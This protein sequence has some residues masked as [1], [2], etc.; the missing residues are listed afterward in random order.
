MVLFGPNGSGK[1]NLLEALTLLFGTRQS[2]ALFN[3]SSMPPIGSQPWGLSA[4]ITNDVAAT[5]TTGRLS[6]DLADIDS[7]RAQFGS[8]FLD[9]RNW[10]QNTD[11]TWL[12]SVAAWVDS[13]AVPSEVRVVIEKALNAS[14]VKYTLEEL[15]P[16]EPTT[17]L[18]RFSRVLMIRKDALSDLDRSNL[19]GLP[20]VFS[21]LS[22]NPN[23]RSGWAE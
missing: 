7:L 21:P 4:V 2:L 22:T 20:P 3:W 13:I 1:S 8:R 14:V 16:E 9:E 10:W 15:T 12:G 23:R 17:S 5:R 18:R 11:P 6:R 19:Q